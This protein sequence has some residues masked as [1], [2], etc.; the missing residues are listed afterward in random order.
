MASRV[1][2]IDLG[3]T[4]SCVS[5]LDG[6]KPVVIPNGEGARTTP[7]VVAITKSDER[8][9]GQIAKRQ[10]VT[11]STRTIYAVKRLIGRKFS[12]EMVEKSKSV[13]SYKVCNVQNGD[14]WVD[15]DGKQFSPSEISSLVLKKMKEIAEDYLGSE[16]K[17][18]VI[19]VPAYFNDAQRQATKDAGKIANLNV[20]RIL[21]EPTAAA[22]AYG[23]DKQG[24]EKVAVF[25]LGGGTFDISILELSDGVYQVK[26]T[27]GDTFLGGEDFDHAIMGHL[28]KKFQDAEG[29]DLS[30][31]PLALQRIKEASE[32]AKH[33]LSS[34]EETTVELPFITAVSGAPKHLKQSINRTTLNDLC[35]PLIDRLKAP[36]ETALTDAK[37]S[38]K[39]IQKVLMVG[40]M[41]RMPAV[42]EKVKEIFGQAGDVSINPDEVVAVG[43]SIQGGVLSGEVNNVVLLD[44]TPLSLG[45]ETAGGVFTKIIEKNTAIPTL[46]SKV[47]STAADDQSFV[48]VHVLQGERELAEFNKTLAKFDLTDIMSAP[49][50]VPQIEVTFS[51]DSNGI[52]DV[53]AKDL[54]TAKEQAIK[55]TASSGLSESEIKKMVEE[56]KTFAD[57]DSKKKELAEAR[58]DLESLVFTSEKSVHEFQ[59]ELPSELAER[60]IKVLAQ[61]KAALEA[62]DFNQISSARTELNEAAHAMAEHIYGQFAGSAGESK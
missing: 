47:F 41:T 60:A 58:I 51:I 5:V 35:R 2:G 32:K 53:K 57:V 7:S 36:C 1:I 38:A 4:N 62:N 17:D 20:L 33:E 39:D 45:V 21:N 18:A 40:G 28:L 23:I 8:L 30:K 52:V 14:A 24:T 44:V 11:N 46:K 27:N 50:G 19:T 26:S 56:A 37:L 25:D 29:V 55:I 48:S 43:A 54:G 42:Q 49:R 31:D 3:T 16:V 13:L 12:D 9:V 61:A 59:S 15:I 6:G 10:A 22:L 34:S